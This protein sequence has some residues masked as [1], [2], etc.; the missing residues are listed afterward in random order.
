MYSEGSFWPP[1]IV[2]I[3]SIAATAASIVLT[4]F[5][6]RRNSLHRKSQIPP[7]PTSLLSTTTTT[8]PSTSPAVD[9]LLGEYEVFLNFCGQDTRK[10]FTDFLYTYLHGAG[11]RTFRDDNELRVGEEIGPELLKAIKGSKISIPIFSKSYASSKWCLRELAEM[12]E[13]QLNG[14]Q[15]IFPIFYDVEPSG[16]K[17]QSGSYEKAFHDHKKDLSLDEK[18]VQRW[19][20]ALRIV[21]E[22]KGLELKK[23]TNGHEGELVKKVVQDVL[24]AL[25]KNFTQL[26]DNV[27]GLY[28]HVIAMKEL[29]NV[30]ST[31]VRVVGI[32][33]MGGLGKTTIAKVIYNQLCEG[34]ECCCFLED[35]R[36]NSDHRNGLVNLQTQ[37]LSKIRKR[38]VG[39]INNVEEGINDIKDAVGMKKVFIVLDDVDDKYQFDKLVGKC[40]WFGAGSRIIVTTRNK[41]VLDKLEATCQIENLRD[42]YGSYEP[43]LMKFNHALEL[44]SRYAFMRESPPEDYGILAQKVVSSAGG[45]PLVL[46]TTGSL[47]FGKDRALWEEKLRK[48]EEIPHEQVLEKL[49]ISFDALDY[50]Q[51]QI[52]LDI[53]CFFTGKDLIN[54]CYMWDACRFYP[55]DG[56]NALF[57]RHMVKI[58]DDNKLRMHDHLRDLGRQIVREENMTEQGAR[59]RLWS[60]ED[61]LDLFESHMVTTKVV[62]LNLNIRQDSEDCSQRFVRE[63]F[64]QLRNLR[65]LKLGWADLDGDF[66]QHLSKLRWL[67]WE[68]PGNYWPTN[69]H[70]KNLVI[71]NLS[72]SKVTDNWKGWSE[73]EKAKGLKVLILTKCR[74]L[75]RAPIFSQF[76][77]LERLSLRG[78]ENLEEIDPSIQDLTNLRVLD[79]SGCYSLRT[80]DCSAF[81]ALETLKFGECTELCTLDGLEQLES[82]RYLDLSGCESLE[83]LLDL[84][85]CKKL[86]KVVMIWCLELTQIQGLDRLESLQLLNMTACEFVERLPGL[87]NLKMLKELHLGSCKKLLEVDGLE[88]L[89][90]LEYLNMCKCISIERLPD[91]SNLQK[92]KKLILC[93]CKKLREVRGLGILEMLERLDLSNCPSLV[94]VPDLSNLQNLKEL[95]ISEWDDLTEIRGLGELKSLELLNISKCSSI[96]Q[97]PD[98]SNLKN[99]KEIYVSDCEKLTE[100]GGLE[101]LMKSLERL[102]VS[103]CNSLENLPYLPNTKILGRNSTEISKLLDA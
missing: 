61:A 53:A 12:V 68:C 10:G 7:T 58:E 103:G 38:E 19:M 8:A 15:K 101:E 32:H 37:L 97:L 50:E 29:L 11:I 54:P 48:L 9:L 83:I 65:F 80:F 98:L 88:F 35:I 36:A 100:I 40:N 60:R 43:H 31:G 13:C 3:A 17:H 76:S 39:K 21:A 92:L 87:S 75:R 6:I 2:T 70:L 95:F 77:T 93:H 52:F 66:K 20:N 85:K 46:V 56:L 24:L 5:L 23:E 26:P 62:A 45:L 71:L 74:G 64:E 89:E 102:D 42:V 27:V 90:S 96:E 82:L 1:S 69:C 63:D 18:T 59:S 44:F 99:L 14:T 81:S 91:L 41:E 47:L 22:L 57:L 34:F 84:S 30:D 51:K 86:E 33:G 79:M 73:I 94:E 67:K 55:R 72:W 4:W 28:D 25:K 16:V 49:R 78:C